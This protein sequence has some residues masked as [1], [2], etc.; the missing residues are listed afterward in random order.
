MRSPAAKFLLTL[1]ACGLLAT[2]CRGADSVT[3]KIINEPGSKVA[4]KDPLTLNA[5]TIMQGLDALG[6]MDG[7]AH[8]NRTTT[9]NRAKPATLTSMTTAAWPLLP[10]LTSKGLVAE[11][12]RTYYYPNIQEPEIEK[13]IRHHNAIHPSGRL[14]TGTSPTFGDKPT[15]RLAKVEKPLFDQPNHIR[16]QY[17][18]T[19]PPF[20]FTIP[21]EMLKNPL[22]AN[23]PN[24][25]RLFIK[26]NGT[27]ARDTLRN[28]DTAQHVRRI[29]SASFWDGVE[30]PNNPR[31]DYL[32]GTDYEAKARNASRALLDIRDPAQPPAGAND[33][34]PSYETRSYYNPVRNNIFMRR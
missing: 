6:F 18:Y 32:T 11:G 29:R 1:V 16:A 2:V 30:A 22:I 7:A 3:L 20:L 15:Y 27:G 24:M 14:S 17:D 4:E 25:L 23:D 9:D 12:K 5:G 31:A 21:T 10:G 19:G 8:Q 13:P 28:L 33:P 26:T 34:R